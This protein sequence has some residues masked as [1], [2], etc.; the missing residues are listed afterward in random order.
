MGAQRGRVKAALAERGLVD[1]RVRLRCWM[2]L[3]AETTLVS[4]RSPTLGP[5]LP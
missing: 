3:T 4:R 5:V 2:R 1:R